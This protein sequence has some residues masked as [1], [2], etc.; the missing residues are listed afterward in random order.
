MKES[1]L[2]DKLARP[3]QRAS[4]NAGINTLEQLI[5]LSESVFMKFHGIGKNALQTLKVDME[6]TNLSFSRKEKKG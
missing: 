3:A 1:H 5:E 2:F 4:A 6:E